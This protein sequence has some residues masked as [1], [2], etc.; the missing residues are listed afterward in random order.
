MVNGVEKVPRHK[1]FHNGM[2]NVFV[3]EPKRRSR[4]SNA[5]GI[6]KNSMPP[7]DSRYNSTTP[8]V[9]K[10]HATGKSIRQASDNSDMVRARQQ[11]PPSTQSP[12]SDRLMEMAGYRH[13]SAT[14]CMVKVG[15][16]SIFSNSS[17]IDPG[18]SPN[19]DLVKKIYIPVY[20]NNIRVVGCMD[21]G[22][23]I[24]TENGYSNSF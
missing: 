20:L 6:V 22:S 19:T 24:E 9:T 4:N 5:P 11:T 8:L 17:S 14:A 10:Y 3:D 7:C 13:I 16:T 15:R 1:K 12:L 2:Q 21:S 23:D 18:I